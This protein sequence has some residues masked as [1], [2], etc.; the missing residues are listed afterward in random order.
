MTRKITNEMRAS[1]FI[2]VEFIG[3]KEKPIKFDGLTLF[4]LLAWIFV[5]ICFRVF[6]LFPPFPWIHGERRRRRRRRR[7]EENRRKGGGEVK[8][9]IRFWLFLFQTQS[10]VSLVVSFLPILF[11]I[12]FFM[13]LCFIFVCNFFF[14]III[15]LFYFI[16]FLKFSLCRHSCIINIGLMFAIQSDRWCTFHLAFIYWRA[17]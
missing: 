16:F 7:G 4:P 8:L 17:R 1:I 13:F 2:S 12:F 9:Q 6:C 11:S 3:L 5:V 14:S 10:I 15:L